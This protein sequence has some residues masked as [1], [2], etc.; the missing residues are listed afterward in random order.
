MGRF[1]SG[2]RTLAGNVAYQSFGPAE[3]MDIGPLALTRSYDQ[4]YQVTGI[5]AGTVLNYA[6]ALN[7]VWCRREK[8]ISRSLL[9]L[10]EP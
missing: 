10:S 2:G 4:R 6:M 5:Q 3:S 1:A 8:H 9:G 7:G